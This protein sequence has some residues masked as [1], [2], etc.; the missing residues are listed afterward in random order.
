MQAVTFGREAKG[1]K[2]MT[3]VVETIKAGLLSFV[4]VLGGYDSSAQ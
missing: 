1:L 3:K 2:L 4:E